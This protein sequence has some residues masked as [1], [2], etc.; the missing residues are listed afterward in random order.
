VAVP[1]WSGEVHLHHRRCHDGSP[2]PADGLDMISPGWGK[3]SWEPSFRSSPPP[4]SPRMP[5]LDRAVPHQG[6]LPGRRALCGHVQ[7]EPTMRRPDAERGRPRELRRHGLHSAVAN[8]VTSPE[9]PAPASPGLIESP[10][11]RP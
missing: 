1:L 3:S 7:G 4:P 9:P 6:L 11:R 8:A 10:R 2:Y 5:W